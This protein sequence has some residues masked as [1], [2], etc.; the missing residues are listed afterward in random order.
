LRVVVAAIGRLRDPPLEELIH[1][2]TRRCPWP[3]EFLEHGVK[4]RV[5]PHRQRDA[6]AALL[7]AALPPG[8]RAIALHEHGR[9]LSSRELAAQLGRWRE[10]GARQV[11][12][13]IG[14]ADGHGAAV[15][16]RADL[17]L[18]LGQLTWPHELV[19][20]LLAEQLYRAATIQAG[21]PYHR[22]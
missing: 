13:L 21:H 15:L 11:V 1:R 4:G 2:Y 20:L 18:S 12:F 8:A 14:G 22:D 10:H 5:E 17:V 16:E 3:I 6:E 9:M 19:R 7:L